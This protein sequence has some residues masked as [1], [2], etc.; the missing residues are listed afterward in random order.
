MD[1][2]KASEAFDYVCT[3]TSNKYNNDNDDYNFSILYFYNK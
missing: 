1:I 3:L 2:M